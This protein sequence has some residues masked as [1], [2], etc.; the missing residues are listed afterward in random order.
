[1]LLQKKALNFSKSKKRST[2]SSTP[3]TDHVTDMTQA[4][5]TVSLSEGETVSGASISKKDCKNT[6]NQMSIK[7][8]LC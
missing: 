4:I 3:A 6:F 8:L 1:M 5:D 7:G 2:E